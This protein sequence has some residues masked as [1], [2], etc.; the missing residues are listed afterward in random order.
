MDRTTS[1]L[2][3]VRLCARHGNVLAS[4]TTI[5]PYWRQQLEEVKRLRDDKDN[6]QRQLKRAQEEA[7]SA[8]S[9]ADD[10]C[11]AVQTSCEA[12]IQEIKVQLVSGEGRGGGQ[13]GNTLLTRRESPQ[14]Q[15]QERARTSTARLEDGAR[16]SHR[17]IADLNQRLADETEMRM[18]LERRLSAATQ[19]AAS[20][21]DVSMSLTQ[22]LS[23]KSS[24]LLALQSEVKKV[25]VC[26][27]V[28]MRF[29]HLM[30]LCAPSLNS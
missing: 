4:S 30:I 24:S 18:S 11:R 19:A 6:L 3:R 8:R 1:E 29:V 25:G 23:T 5:T 28:D 13:G 20:E 7:A 27:R 15:E 22:S 17:E 14:L 10:Q 16:A 12:R 9:A 26:G 2:T 21:Q